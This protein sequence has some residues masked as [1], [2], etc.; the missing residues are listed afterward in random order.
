MRV[1]TPD[2]IFGDLRSNFGAAQANFHTRL[3]GPDLYWHRRI[4]MCVPCSTTCVLILAPANCEAGLK[5]PAR[6]GDDGQ[7]QLVVWGPRRLKV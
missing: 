6:R 5:G 2:S 7:P 1:A 4:P 3:K